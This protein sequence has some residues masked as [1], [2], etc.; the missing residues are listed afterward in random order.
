MKIFNVEEANKTILKRKALHR[1]EYSPLT[2]QRTEDFFGVGISPPQAV[3]I[4][5]DSVENEG[6]MAIRKWSEKLDDYK[7]TEL[8][9]SKSKLKRGLGTVRSKTSKGYANRRL[10]DSR[11]P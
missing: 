10:P 1:M 6:D 7:S 9:I 2:T 3:E 5:L 4:I 11:F 8:A